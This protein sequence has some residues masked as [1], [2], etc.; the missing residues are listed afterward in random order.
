MKESI[1]PNSNLSKLEFFTLFE[2]IVDKLCLPE[3]KKNVLY[4]FIKLILPFDSNLPKN[5]AGI[6]KKFK[7]SFIK[8][9]KLCSFCKKP[10]QTILSNKRCSNQLCLSMPALFKSKNIKIF[11]IDLL[12]QIKSILDKNYEK[13]IIYKGKY[14]LNNFLK[15]SFNF[16]KKN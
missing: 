4:N 13:I 10:N 7:N 5:Y 2:S 12:Y 3:N 14:E 16:L 15:S 9:E 1:F 8:S 11:K 6:N